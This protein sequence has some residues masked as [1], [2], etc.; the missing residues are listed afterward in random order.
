[1]KRSLFFS[2]AIFSFLL[3]GAAIAAIEESQTDIEFPIAELGNCENEDACFSYCE[4]PVHYE[5]C[6]AFGT[7]NG[8]IEDER[9]DTELV[10]TI[11]DG[12]GPGGC[13][14]QVACEAYCTNANNIIECV[15]FAEENDLMDEEELAEA[16]QVAAA[17]QS[18]AS[19][20]GGCTSKDVCEAYCEDTSHMEEC[21]A[22]AEAAGFMST[23]ELEEARKMM[24]LM[25]EGAMPGGCT[26]QETCDAY[27][28]NENHFEECINFGVKAGF[29]T[30][31]EADQ[32]KAGG[33]MGGPG[34]C[35][36][37]EEC[38]TYCEDPSNME[39]CINFSVEAGFMTQEEAEKLLQGGFGQE[40]ESGD[41]EEFI[42]H[43]GCKS[44][45][46]CT[47]YCQANPQA[48][49]GF[50][51]E[52][53][54]QQNDGFSP[55][56]EITPSSGCTSAEECLE[57]YGEPPEGFEKMLEAPDQNESPLEMEPNWMKNEFE[58]IEPLFDASPES[59]FIN[60]PQNDE[61]SFVEPE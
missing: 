58:G 27:C 10:A 4:K 22:F 33:M 18:G 30:Q 14:S 7:E 42:G 15:A 24:T 55:L 60:P 44:E 37:E 13:T 28:Q 5:A 21:V 56:N 43:G 45:E 31:E 34:G 54:I 2:F 40:G 36:G 47:A 39:E 38:N 59:L 20:P 6:F 19:L 51:E 49:G 29:M 32:I 16:K 1:M 12:G 53:E 35:K 17:I 26:S 3:A 50:V 48:C 61:P 8:L 23:E 41:E 11:A 25:K 57:L 9:I 52:Q 46:E